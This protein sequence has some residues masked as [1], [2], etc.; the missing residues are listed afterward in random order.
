MSILLVI[1]I[2]SCVTDT[3]R[4]SPRLANRARSHLQREV[5]ATGRD[6]PSP[7][8]DIVV[9]TEGTA[10]QD[11]DLELQV[12]TTRGHWGEGMRGEAWR[13]RPSPKHDIV[14]VTEGTA[15]QDRDLELQ[16]WKVIYMT[17]VSSNL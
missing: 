14:V 10:K 12:H 7:K 3:P 4:S 8:H 6:R 9:V 1:T 13:D 2:Y 5:G 17:T 15:K 16:V 11:R